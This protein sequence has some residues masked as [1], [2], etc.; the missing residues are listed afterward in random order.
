[1]LLEEAL[2]GNSNNNNANPSIPGATSPAVGNAP[3]PLSPHDEALAIIS[4]IRDELP[5]GGTAA[6]KRFVNLFPLIASRVFGPWN[7]PVPEGSPGGRSPVPSPRGGGGGDV[8]SPVTSPGGSTYSS[9]ASSSPSSPGE[10]DY[11]HA[12]GG[13]LG[14]YSS[15]PS[16]RSGGR[17]GNRA[18]PASSSRTQSPEHDPIVRLL[19][20]PRGRTPDGGGNNGGYYEPTLLD[21]L[22]AES[23]HRPSVRFKFP[24]AGL[25]AVLN[26]P[27]VEDWKV[28]FWNEFERE[29][30]KAAA[31]AVT[32]R[33]GFGSGMQGRVAEE[34]EN[35]KPPGVAGKEN[36]T[37]ILLRL[38]SGAPRDQM[39]L[40][41]Y[42]ERM[43]QHQRQP[44]GQHHGAFANFGSPSPLKQRSHGMMSTRV[45][46]Y[47]TP[48]GGGHAPNVDEPN[49]ELTMLEYYLFL[50]VR[51]PLANA[52]WEMQH[53]DQRER[54]RRVGGRLAAPYGQRVYSH[55]FSTYLDHL[56]PRGR[57]YDE[58]TLGVGVDCFDSDRQSD[59]AS[60][61]FLRLLVEFWIE[62]PN[63]A[64]AAEDAVARYRRV[65]GCLSG[66]RSQTILQPSM[67]DSL[68]LAQPLN[69]P[70]RSPPL[71]VQISV[72]TLVNHLISDKSMRDLVEIASGRV[73]RRQRDDREGAATPALVNESANA[74][75][76]TRN[77]GNALPNDNQFVP[78]CL[79]PALT[80]IQPSL[81]NYIRLGLACGAVHDRSS[82]FHNA[83]KTWLVWVEPWNYVMKRR[84]VVTRSGSRGET[85]GSHRAG[86]FLRNAAATVSSHHRVEYY[87]SYLQ[88]KPTSLSTYSAQWE[89]YVLSNTHFYTVPLAIFL[90]RARELDFSSSVEYPRSL[91]LV[92]KVLRIY[93][94]PLVNV[95]NRVSNQ[96][97]DVL[98]MSLCARHGTNMGTFHPPK[99]WKLM[100]CQLNATNLLEEMFSQYQKRRSA[101]DFFDRM[102][103][104]LSALFD[105]K[106]G[107]DEAALENILSQVRYLVSLPLDY[108]VLPEEPRAS[109][110]FRLLRLLGVGAKVAATSAISEKLP[111]RT[112]DGKLT[113][114]GRQQIYLGQRKCNPMD[115]HYIGDPM[116]ARAKSYEISAI[117]DL[118]I[119]VSNYLNKKLGLV[120]PTS[121]GDFVGGA[122]DDALLKKMREMEQYQRG[123][124]RINL[125]C[126][127]DYRNVIFAVI[128]LW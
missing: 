39:E 57:G 6:E 61:L 28:S 94:K 51:F 106:I 109:S 111:D 96:R 114:L 31:A 120:P 34:R 77:E 47:Q 101:M 75:G 3:M 113:D 78:W 125:R 128:V 48:N 22:S 20:A 70:F 43:Y 54:Q 65:R 66:S 10:R 79:P 85:S 63:V 119:V 25:S 1:M 7:I 52:S 55:L 37:R 38:L 121:G 90:K 21:A 108:Q 69:Q 45:G 53:H 24:L 72:H 58:R 26:Q 46:S 71:Q 60:E 33:G 68:E 11:L 14:L 110:G 98:S 18:S 115:I 102:D 64:P 67:S 103:A 93:T 15:P 126:L 88:P 2:A 76:S 89:A 107:S 36:A 97:A 4:F 127:A 112:L 17:G 27:L 116:L 104:K 84:A 82:I 29:A 49:L 32:P 41:S 80:A 83:L 50:F 5:A 59:R 19:R 23:I 86:E 9:P 40:R 117:V 73:Q 12:E 16:Q 92:Q 124:F 118:N 91:E 8:R 42:F 87:P 56:L 95:L 44:Q 122:E 62:G 30:A 81:F 100:D 13:W 74:T 35:E 105:G 123:G 99:T